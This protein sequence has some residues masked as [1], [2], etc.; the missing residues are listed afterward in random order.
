MVC[1]Q[2]SWRGFM[3]RYEKYKKVDLPYLEEVPNHWILRNRLKDIIVSNDSGAWGDD[4]KK[5]KNDYICLRIADFDE[6]TF[7]NKVISELTIRNYKKSDINKLLLQKGDILIEKSGGGEK[8]PVG[9]T[10]IFDK[11]YEALFANF[12][13]RLVINNKLANN[14]FILYYFNMLYS[15]KVNTMYIKQTTG[16][17]N[18]DIKSFLGYEKCLL[19]PIEEQE[20]IVKYLDWKINEIDKLIKIEKRKI[21]ELFKGTS[22]N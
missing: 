5:D 13:N 2:V 3:N 4:K 18:L 11:E 15:N 9:R 17:Q 12:M 16:I 7:K 22:I 8:T 21:A 20:K 6:Y 1:L 19:P 14:K 10:V